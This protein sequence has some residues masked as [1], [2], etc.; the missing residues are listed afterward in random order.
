MHL[1]P[2]SGALRLC[3][4][5]NSVAQKEGQNFSDLALFALKFLFNWTDL[6]TAS[7]QVDR[8]TSCSLNLHSFLIGLSAH[9]I[10]KAKDG[11]HDP[12][13]CGIDARHFGERQPAQARCVSG[14]R[15]IRSAWWKKKGVL[16]QRALPHL[17][18]FS[19]LAGSS[20]VLAGFFLPV[21]TGFAPATSTEGGIVEQ[22]SQWDFL[23]SLLS[24]VE[25]TWLLCAGIIFPVLTVATILS[26]GLVSVCFPRLSPVLARWKWRGALAGAVIEWVTMLSLLLLSGLSG[27]QIY[28]GRG[29]ALSLL[30]FMLLLVGTYR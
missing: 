2:R 22:L 28:P 4:T 26:I 27:A 12:Y 18:T 15:T 17:P 1:F 25:G 7:S 29:F 21:V 24:S 13:L 5:S 9:P 10:G 14:E 11:T 20:L 30:G 3:S 6:Y 16:M 8:K 19:T 23:P